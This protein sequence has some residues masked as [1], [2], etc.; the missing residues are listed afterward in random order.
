MENQY[1]DNIL[2]NI[3]E[4]I[5]HFDIENL[6]TLS[7]LLLNNVGYML[8]RSIYISHCVDKMSIS[9]SFNEFYRFNK[10]I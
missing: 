6:K 2:D 1:I 7:K 9:Y 10:K 5:D 4:D 8:K 3:W